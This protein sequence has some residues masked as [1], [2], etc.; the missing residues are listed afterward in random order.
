MV[1]SLLFNNIC[2]IGSPNPSLSMICIDDTR[3]HPEYPLHKIGFV[4]FSLGKKM[5][6]NIND[7]IDKL[8]FAF[9]PVR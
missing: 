6:E 8:L 1:K 2:K 4:V 7:H 5:S 3:G 9:F